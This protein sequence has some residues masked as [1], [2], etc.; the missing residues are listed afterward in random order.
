MVSKKQKD[1]RK[2]FREANPELFPKPEPT[3]PKDPTSKKYKQKK[4]KSKFKKQ[5]PNSDEPHKKSSLKKHPLRVPGMRPGERCHRCQGEDHIARNCPQKENKICLSCRRYGHSL[6]NCPNKGDGGAKLCYNCGDTQHRLSDCPNPRQDG[7][8][9]FASC[10]VCN[11]QGHLSKN[12]PKNTHGIYPKGGSCKL[13]GGVTHLAK[14]CPSKQ[15]KGSDSSQQGQ[16]TSIHA[17]ARGQVTKFTSGDDLEDDFSTVKAVVTIDTSTKLDAE[18][19]QLTK[20]KK[21]AP[22]VVNFVG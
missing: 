18:G 2:R 12:C 8:T 3:Q 21:K 15:N 9:K 5:K 20:Q 1:A 11:E 10:F 22:K 14:D 17:M 13:C 6:M 7:G 4:E 16:R 19:K